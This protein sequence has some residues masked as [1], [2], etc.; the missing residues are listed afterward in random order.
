M[1]D[2]LLHSLLS[3]VL[4]QLRPHGTQWLLDSELFDLDARDG[5]R[6]WRRPGPLAERPDAAVAAEGNTDS[7][8]DSGPDA[9]ARAH[10]DAKTCS[11]T[12]ADAQTGPDP[13]TANSADSRSNPQAGPRSDA[14]ARSAAGPRGADT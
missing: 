10:P 8:P 14:E 4:Q 2:A 9:N 13:R 6:E 3:T 7:G 1:P 12:R 11:N 5:R